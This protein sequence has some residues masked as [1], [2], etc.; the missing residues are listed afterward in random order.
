MGGLICWGTSHCHSSSW[1]QKRKRGSVERRGEWQA[2]VPLICPHSLFCVPFLLS[3]SREWTWKN[4]V[5]GRQT[6]APPPSVCLAVATIAFDLLNGMTQPARCSWSIPALNPV[7]VKDL[8]ELHNR[9]TIYCVSAA[10]D[11]QL[12]PPAEPWT[13]YPPPWSLELLDLRR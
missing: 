2:R 1:T 6:L 5:V 11:P 13:T 9:S 7:T 4:S 3:K 12:R 10:P 8:T